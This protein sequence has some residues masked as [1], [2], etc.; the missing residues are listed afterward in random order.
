MRLLTGDMKATYNQAAL[1]IG[2]HSV[3]NYNNVLAEMTKHSFPVYTFSKQKRYLCRHLVKH[4]RINL[5]SFI[6]RLQE[7]I[8]YLA[9]SLPDTEGQET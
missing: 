2:I 7:W 1:D 3:D 8:T 9:E 5:S 4:R 6:S